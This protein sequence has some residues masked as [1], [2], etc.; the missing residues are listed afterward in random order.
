[1]EYRMRYRDIPWGVALAVLPGKMIGSL[2]IN[3]V[4]RFGN[5]WSEILLRWLKRLVLLLLII[6]FFGMLIMVAD[7][8]T[9]GR[10][11]PAML[12]LFN[13]L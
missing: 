10:F 1:M 12:G 13:S 11:V 9:D 8:I 2:I 6:V 4:I 3:P 7:I 5:N